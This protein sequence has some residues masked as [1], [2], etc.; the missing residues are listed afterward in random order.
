[1]KKIIVGS[2]R[3]ELAL[4]QAK[5]FLKTVTDAHPELEIEIKE[6]VTK[7]DKILDV[8]LSKVGGKGLFIKEI[9]QALLEGEID[10]A[11]HSM[12][13]V[14]SELHEDLIIACVPPREDMRDA[15]I[16][17][18]DV[19]FKDL[20]AGSVVGT[21]SLRRQAQLLGLRDDIKVEWIRGNINTR[22]E[23]MRTGNYDAIILAAAGIK[24]MGWEHI[25]TEYFSVEDFVPAVAQGALGIEV[26]KDNRELIDILKTVENKEDRI[27][28][29]AERTFLN[30]MDGSCH[31]PIGGYAEYEDGELYLTGLIMDKEGNE[32]F[33]VKKSHDNAIELGNIVADEME[34]IGAKELLDAYNE[35]A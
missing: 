18:D 12:K 33:I 9:E 15:Y 14:P 22:L 23:K 34:K 19:L 30:R 6:I 11:I 31:V 26:R 17:K 5:Q 29:T 13:D 27:C 3:S 8:Q 21:S 24:R 1:M 2:R 16:A 25:V 32:K 20:P 4:T 35:E 28:I 10:I 7:G